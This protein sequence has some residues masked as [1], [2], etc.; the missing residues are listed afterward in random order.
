MPV[1][2]LGPT[3]MVAQRLVADQRSRSGRVV[4]NDNLTGVTRK[5]V[6]VELL[7]VGGGGARGENSA[8]FIVGGGGAGGFVLATVAVPVGEHPVT[9]AASQVAFAN[10]QNSEALGVIARGGGAGGNVVRGD[11]ALGGSGGGGA[12]NPSLPFVFSGGEGVSNQGW[13]GGNAVSATGPAGGGGGAGGPGVGAVAGPGRFS[14]ITGANTE[15]ARGGGADGS[16]TS[17]LA[18]SGQATSDPTP[19]TQPGIVILRY[20]TGSMT[21]IG[22]TVTT[23]GPWTIHTFT[24]SGTFTRTG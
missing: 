21:A 23:F 14:D 17:T 16:S 8:S 13:R 2:T 18:G 9:V 11:G 12:V 20:R 10:G 4:L 24:T 5:R 1:N 22:G 19:T 7:V 15:Y 6:P 3:F